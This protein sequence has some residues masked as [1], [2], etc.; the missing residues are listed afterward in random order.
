MLSSLN[1]NEFIYFALA[2]FSYLGILWFLVRSL[3]LLVKPVRSFVGTYWGSLTE[4]E[5]GIFPSGGPT[6]P[7]RDKFHLKVPRVCLG[8]F[9]GLS[10]ASFRHAEL[11]V[12]PYIHILSAGLI[13][14]R[15]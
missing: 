13:Y 9:A 1:L 12:S 4:R 14:F 5:S 2:G 8:E 6:Q 7:G 10:T 15:F 11:R 3:Q